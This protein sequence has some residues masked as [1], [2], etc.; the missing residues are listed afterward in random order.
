MIMGLYKC[1]KCGCCENTA[2]GLYWT[3]NLIENYDWTGLE[4]YKG[5]PLCSE[6]GPTHFSSGEPTKF[7]VWHNRFP[8]EPYKES[9]NG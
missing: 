8:K 2:L 7:G 4:E 9:G 3:R 5:Q 1:A 6:C